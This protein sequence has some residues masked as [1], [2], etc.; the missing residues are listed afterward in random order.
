MSMKLASGSLVA[1]LMAVLAAQ[2]QPPALKKTK[3]TVQEITANLKTP[4]ETKDF[5]KKMTVKEALNLLH[6]KLAE[7]KKPVVILI[8]QKAF[9]ADAPEAPDYYDLAVK[10]KLPAKAQPAAKLLVAITGQ[11]PTQNVTYVVRAGYVDITTITE[12]QKTK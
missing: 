5:M 12:A 3:Q 11:F 2:A 10:L 8:N 7:K 6:E 4:V 1:V 9:K